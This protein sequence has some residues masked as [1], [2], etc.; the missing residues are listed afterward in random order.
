MGIVVKIH[1]PIHR[2]LQNVE[3]YRTK[4]PNCRCAIALL[5]GHSGHSFLFILKDQLLG[6]PKRCFA[7][8]LEPKLLVMWERIYIC[9]N[10]HIY[11][12]QSAVYFIA[13]YTYIV[14]SRNV[15]NC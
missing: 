14:C 12:I 15:I 8:T 3:Y 5:L 13:L 9:T 6:F 11:S 1:V 2:I 10:I 7:A 4:V